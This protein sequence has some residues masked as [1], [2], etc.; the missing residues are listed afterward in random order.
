MRWRGFLKGAVINHVNTLH[1]QVRAHVQQHSDCDAH[2]HAYD[3]RATLPIH[4]VCRIKP[5]PGSALTLQNDGSFSIVN[6]A[7]YPVGDAQITQVALVVVPVGT[8]V[9]NSE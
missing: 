8:A 9:V 2:A 6:W 1:A 7:S 5:Q 3:W 4:I